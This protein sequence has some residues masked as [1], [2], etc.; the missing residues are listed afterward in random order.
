MNSEFHRMEGENYMDLNFST[1]GMT[2][3]ERYALLD[4]IELIPIGTKCFKAG[5]FTEW[6]EEI[7]VTEENQKIVTMCWNSTYFLDKNKADRV[8]ARAHM[9]YSAYQERCMQCSY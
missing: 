8:T 7:I 1:E 2:I 6:T 9:E 5:D 4:Q 3:S